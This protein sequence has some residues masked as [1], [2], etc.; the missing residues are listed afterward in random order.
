M[1]RCNYREKYRKL[2]IVS[3]NLKKNVLLKIINSK[4]TFFIILL[5]N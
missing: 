3:V 4:L 2:L 5:K 1:L